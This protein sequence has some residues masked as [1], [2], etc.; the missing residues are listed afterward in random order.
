MKNENISQDLT[1]LSTYSTYF[2]SSFF[3][4]LQNCNI[5]SQEGLFH[6]LI[7]LKGNIFVSLKISVLL[8]LRKCSHKA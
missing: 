8:C 3:L 5:N 4:P 2:I 6:Y 7:L 1:Y